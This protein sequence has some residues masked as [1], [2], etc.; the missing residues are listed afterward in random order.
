MKSLKNK[1]HTII[2][3]SALVTIII[4]F[5]GSII[6]TA[7]AQSL[8]N[9]EKTAA[10]KPFPVRA[11]H[12][13]LRI[14]VMTIPALKNFAKELSDFG[15][16]TLIMEWEASY[17]YEK[18]QTISNKYAY[19]RSEVKEFVSY[20]DSLGIDVI[21]LQQCFGHV[22]YILRH[23]R[24]SELRES[25]KDPSQVCPLKI[26]ADKELFTDLFA[27]MASLHNSKYIHI[28]GDETRLL[29]HCSIC[30]EKVAK[31]G[32][33]ALFADYLSAI[34]NI[35]VKM[36][37]VPV[38]WSDIVLKYPQVVNQL[39]K[40]TVY[41]DW[42]YGWKI[43]HFGDIGK[44][45]EKGL[46]FWGAPAIR[47]HPDNWYTTDWQ[48]HFN[49]QRDFIPYARQAG[50]KGIVMT[51]WSTSGVYGFTWDTNYEMIDMTA[52]RNVYPLSGF[53]ILI[54]AYAQALRQAEPLDPEAFVVKYAQDR[55]SLTSSDGKKLWKIMKASPQTVDLSSNA[56]LDELETIRQSVNEAKKLM[57]L[58]KPKA[59]KQEFEHLRLML[60][61][62]VYYLD[63]KKVESIYE[64]DQYTLEKAK[65]I[66]PELKKMLVESEK[67]NNR[68]TELNKGFLHPDEIKEQ[69]FIRNQK[70]KN[71]Y[72][73]VRNCTE[74]N[75]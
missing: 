13:D 48:K 39:P 70:L 33:S 12:I 17:P 51:S 30:K 27:D 40:E 41:V 42:N 21:P 18:H 50:Y 23:S 25:K 69:N 7:N 58:L 20:C 24:Y 6:S 29:G 32:T 35:V 37:K 8:K 47:S 34:C 19:S 59:H 44:L 9:E 5:F 38:L 1:S 49:N 31:D 10:F 64:S 73:I 60:D 67:L 53:R 57:A 55:F 66:L 61:L 56:G 43:N 4:L 16:N 26:E 75:N 54:A 65:K 71:I 15:I 28:G 36:G 45:L 72:T 74:K 46:N 68:F 63:F 52:I 14:Q 22:E 62:R 3:L 11:F 2:N